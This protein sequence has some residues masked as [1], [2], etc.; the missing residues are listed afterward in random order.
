MTAMKRWLPLACFLVCLTLASPISAEDSLLQALYPDITSMPAP[1]WVSPGTRLA[2][3]VASARVP[4]DKELY[5]RDE[6]GAFMDQYGNRYRKEDATERKSSCLRGLVASFRDSVPPSRQDPR[7]RPGHRV[8]DICLFQRR[9]AGRKPG[10][11]HLR[12]NHVLRV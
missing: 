1:D 8:P 6:D 4:E 3:D 2:Y 11:W 5:Y 10:H 12:N 9:P 7:L